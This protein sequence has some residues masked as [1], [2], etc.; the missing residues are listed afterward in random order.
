M[1]FTLDQATAQRIDRT[2]S[3]LG[4]PKSGVVREAIA[5]YAARV[6][7]LSENE[8]RRMLEV[9]DSVLPNIPQKSAKTVDREIADLRRARR[10]GGRRSTSN[11]RDFADIPGLDVS[12][13]Q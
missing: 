10:T 7:K 8:R 4:M 11:V 2:A 13:P 3:R 1:T 12:R 9:F 6:G 5:E